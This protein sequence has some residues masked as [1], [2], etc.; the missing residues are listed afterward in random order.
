[1]HSLRSRIALFASP[2]SPQVALS[3]LRHE[4]Q[5]R[6][7]VVEL[8]K[9]LAGRLRLAAG[10]VSLK[11]QVISIIDHPTDILIVAAFYLAYRPLSKGLYNESSFLFS[12]SWSG[13]LLGFG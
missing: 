7:G 13:R 1:M 4:S 9:L 2:S 10:G 12:H 11:D 6:Q 3:H 5:F 8:K